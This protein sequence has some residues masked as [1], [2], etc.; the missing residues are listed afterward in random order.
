MRKYGIFNQ[1]LVEIRSNFCMY[2]FQAPEI[3]DLAEFPVEDQDKPKPMAPIPHESFLA[4]KAKYDGKRPATETFL[5]L[6]LLKRNNLGQCQFGCGISKMVGPKQ[7][8]FCPK[9]NIPK[10]FFFKSV[11]E[12]RF[13]KKCQNRTFKVNFQCQKSTEFLKKKPFI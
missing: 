8:H 12:L 3:H 5:D 11:D 10:G 2:S 7:Q 4:K 1:I 13:V 9:I 6:K